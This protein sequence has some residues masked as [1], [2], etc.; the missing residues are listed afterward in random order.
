MELRIKKAAVG[1]LSDG[2]GKELRM[3]K[4][5]ANQAGGKKVSTKK[6]KVEGKTFW[7]STQGQVAQARKA[8]QDGNLAD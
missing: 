1:G 4:N 6:K 7:R 8:V 5:A 2:I 3:F